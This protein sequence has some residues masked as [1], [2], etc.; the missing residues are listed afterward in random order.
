MPIA[1]QFTRS[2]L[3]FIFLCLAIGA[4]AV[5]TGNNVLYFIFS[6]MLGLIVVSGMASR[7]IMMGLSPRVEFPEHIFSGA[8]G[9]CYVTIK[10]RKKR[11]PA[12]GI[13]FLV[14]HKMFPRIS[15]Y[16]FHIPPGGSVNGYASVVFPRRGVFRLEELELQ[17]HF[18][19]SFLIKI[20]RYFPE[21]SVR[22]YPR[23]YRFSDEMIARFT[24]GML[25]ES[26]YRGESHQLLHLRNYTPQD[27]SKRIHWKASAKTEKLLV[28]EF[29]RE[30]GRDLYIYFDCYGSEQEDIRERT[31]SFIA[32]L[33]YLVSEK[34]F[35]ARIVFTDQEFDIEP[36]G[37]LIPLLDFLSEMRPELHP[38]ASPLFPQNPDSVVLF[39]RSKNVPPV[40]DVRAA[41]SHVLFVEEWMPGTEDH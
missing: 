32:S 38:T 5:N 28:K 20:S 8:P 24:E 29:Q 2:G 1:I 11:L 17:T 16:F 27:S 22:V 9:V 18:P 19:F 14:S 13:Q 3:V 39:V 30:Q 7:R 37:S 41:L 35:N 33:A 23:V 12:I 25:V 6:L 40:V 4:A 31:I 10:N 15:R 21:Q 34:G 26:P 36:S